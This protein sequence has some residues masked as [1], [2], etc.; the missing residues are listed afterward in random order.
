MRLFGY[1]FGFFCIE[2][3]Y[4]VMFW[5]IHELLGIFTYGCLVYLL[6]NDL[7]YFKYNFHLQRNRKIDRNRKKSC[8]L[9]S[10]RFF[11]SH[12]RINFKS[13]ISNTNQFLKKISIKL[14]KWKPQFN[15]ISIMKNRNMLDSRKKT[16]LLSPSLNCKENE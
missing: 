16:F 9:S 13:P 5:R 2:L 4:K 15:S 11:P 3:S 8:L 1:S 14:I 10:K 7:K 6:D 12:P